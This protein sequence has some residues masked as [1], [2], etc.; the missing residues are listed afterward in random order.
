MIEFIK[1]I[2]ATDVAI[3]QVRPMLNPDMT[4]SLVR[5][6]GRSGKHKGCWRVR[7]DGA[8]TEDTVNPCRLHAEHLPHG[9]SYFRDELGQPVFYDVLALRLRVKHPELAG[10]PLR[11]QLWEAGALPAF[12]RGSTPSIVPLSLF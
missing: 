1:G 9:G 10:A 12:E 6:V 11:A 8:A 3:G 2:P 7:K 5:V 4:M